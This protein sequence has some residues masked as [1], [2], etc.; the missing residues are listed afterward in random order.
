MPDDLVELKVFFYCGQ[1][2]IGNQVV[3]LS[4][5]FYLTT[6]DP[7]KQAQ[8]HFINKFPDPLIKHKLNLKSILITALNPIGS[9][10]V[11]TKAPEEPKND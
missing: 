2:Q 8:E 10:H 6:T 7:L 4:G 1:T 9:A 11:K 3:M 5:T